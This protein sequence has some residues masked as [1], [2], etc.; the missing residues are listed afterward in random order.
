MHQDNFYELVCAKSADDKHFIKDPLTLNNCGH[1]ICKDCLTNPPIKCGKCDQV[2]DR[3]LSNDKVSIIAKKMVKI[4]L[5]SLYIEMEKL[6]S[7]NI[8]KVLS[9]QINNLY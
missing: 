9:K 2:T 8:E 1:S 7:E 4:Y 5:P 6:L 3:D